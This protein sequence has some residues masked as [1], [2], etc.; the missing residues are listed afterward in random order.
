MTRSILQIGAFDQQE[1]FDSRRATEDELVISGSLQN[2][3]LHHAQFDL[4]NLRQVLRAQGLE[5]NDLVDAVHELR[6]EL[7]ARR[8]DRSAIDLFVELGVKGSRNGREPHGAVDKF[9]HFGGAQVGSH[10]DDALRQVNAPVVA[11]RKRCLVEDPQEQLPQSVRSFFNLVEEY[12][13]QLEL[14]RVP[15]V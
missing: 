14:F 15:L 11:E 1:F 9:I 2:S 13:R 4:E 8:L 6:R 5:D 12:E 10:H 3:L 7:A